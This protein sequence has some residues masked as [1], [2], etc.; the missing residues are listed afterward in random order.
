MDIRVPRWTDTRPSSCH[1]DRQRGS[2]T[3]DDFPVTG[4]LLIDRSIHPS[5]HRP[6]L[7][8]SLEP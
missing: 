1:L 2:T 7:A 4:H 8:P 5:V 3:S 6:A